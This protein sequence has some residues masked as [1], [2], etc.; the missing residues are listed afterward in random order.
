[1][2]TAP[3]YIFDVKLPGVMSEYL[4]NSDNFLQGDIKFHPASSQELCQPHLVGSLTMSLDSVTPGL[5]TTTGTAMS[6]DTNTV[7]IWCKTGVRKVDVLSVCPSPTRYQVYSQEGLS[8]P[9]GKPYPPAGIG[10]TLFYDVTSRKVRALSD[11][12]CWLVAGGSEDAFN[13]CPM[14]YVERAILTATTPASQLY[15]IQLGLGI[16]SQTSITSFRVGGVHSDEH[17]TYGSGEVEVVSTQYPCGGR[18]CEI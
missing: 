12:E 6:I 4:R 17:Q 2:L 3:M 11:L 9:I 14:G 10:H 13:V 18:G 15:L 8:F 1:M 5:K 16:I 7:Q